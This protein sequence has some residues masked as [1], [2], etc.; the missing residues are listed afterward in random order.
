MSNNFKWWVFFWRV[1]KCIVQSVM[2]NLRTNRLFDIHWHSVLIYSR[3]N[4]TDKQK[5]EAKSDAIHS[6]FTQICFNLKHTTLHKVT[7][8]LSIWVTKA[9][10]RVLIKRLCKL[11]KH[12]CPSVA[13]SKAIF[14][15]GKLFLSL[16]E[17]VWFNRNEIWSKQ[18]HSKN[19]E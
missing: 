11:S 16:F 4:E 17:W 13:K 5:I 15:D 2:F 3:L 19:R 12:G 10:E 7:S 8:S 9:M 18:I 6:L 1:S 14:A